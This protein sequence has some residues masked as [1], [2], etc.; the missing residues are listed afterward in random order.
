MIPEY[1]FLKA[2][3]MFEQFLQ[4]LYTVIE[5]ASNLVTNQSI[6]PQPS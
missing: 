2:L 3:F 1:R 5:R 6:A 4:S